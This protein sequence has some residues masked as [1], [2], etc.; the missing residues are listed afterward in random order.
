MFLFYYKLDLKKQLVY[1]IIKFEYEETTVEF[2]DCAAA[3]IA[4]ILYLYSFP[5]LLGRLTYGWSANC[6]SQYCI[7]LS[8][9]AAKLQR[10]KFIFCQMLFNRLI[11]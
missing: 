2:R 5:L 3:V 9:A 4:G 10:R 7:K 8:Y 1:D 11:N 6:E